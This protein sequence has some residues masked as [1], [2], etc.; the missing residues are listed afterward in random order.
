VLLHVNSNANSPVKVEGIRL[1]NVRPFL[2]EDIIL[3]DHHIPSNDAAVEKLLQQKVCPPAAQ[4]T[5]EINEMIGRSLPQE[6]QGDPSMRLPL[7]RL[8]VEYSGY[9]SISP[10]RFGQKYVGR[11]ANPSDMLYFFRKKA[12]SASPCPPS[13]FS[14]RSQKAEQRRAGAAQPLANGPP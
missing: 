7:L 11:V 3:A 8:R 2:F 6:F 14:L 4:M 12:A 10:S 5:S 13:P 9:P 1:K